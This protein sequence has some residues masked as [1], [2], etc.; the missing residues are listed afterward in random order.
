MQ[1]SLGLLLFSDYTLSDLVAHGRLSEELGYRYF[2][3]TDV[4]FTR[5]CYVGL[6]AVAA[7]TQRILLGT[8]VTDPY[9]RHAAITAASIATLDEFCAGRAILGLGTGGA[10]FREI[11]LERKLPVAA[12]RESVEIVRA[13]LRGEKV[14]SQGKVVSIAGGQLNFKP[15]RDKIPVYF[16][17]HGAQVTRL[18]GQIADGVLIANT[19]NPAAFSFYLGQLDEGLAKAGRDKSNLDVGLRVEACI[20][21][22]D[23]AAFA[24]MRK[25]VASRVVSQYPHWDYLD[26]IGIKLPQEFIDIAAEKEKTPDQAARATPLLPAEVVESMVLAGNVERC[27]QQLARGLNGRITQIA[28]RPHAAPGQKI[29]DVIRAFAAEVVPRAL[30]QWQAAG[31]A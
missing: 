22:N 17:T 6:A 26:E 29:A 9:S 21:D 25:R 3:Y 11:G 16:A 31:R 15:V 18:A 8:G 23:E 10:G 20:S 13:L 1:P 4:R 12:M 30:K 24:V 19:L 5:E 2:W 27:A 14:T 28:V 7:Q